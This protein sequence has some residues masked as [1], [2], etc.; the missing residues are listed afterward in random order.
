[1]PGARVGFIVNPLAGIGGRLGFKGSDGAYGLRALMEGAKPVSPLRARRFAAELD[2]IASS[3]G[4]ELSIVAPPGIMGVDSLGG[5]RSVKVEVIS[6]VSPRLWPTTAHDTIRCARMM[7]DGGVDLIVFVGGDGTARNMCE[8][9]GTEVPAL[10][11]PSG[12]KVY[13]SVFAVNPEAAAR[14]VALFSRGGGVRL[15]ERQVVD[16]DEDEFRRGNLVIRFFCRLL[17]PIAGGVV[18]ATKTPVAGST[19]DDIAEY[20]AS[21]LVEDCT[22]YILGP[23]STVAAIAGKMGV[24][25]SFLGVDA[26]HNG[27]LVGVDLSE[28]GILELLDKYKRAVVIVSPIGGQGFI[29]GRGNQQISPEILRRVGRDNLLVVASPEKLKELRVLRVDTG[30]P[31][32]D[33]MLRGYI[34]VLV[35]YDRWRVMRV[36]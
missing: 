26:V 35:G 5:L 7:R 12:V 6:C 18:E 27:R 36:E 23:G 4:L 25:K 3:E 24:P 9:I 34:R 33:E 30:D 8:A 31:E 13:S 1:M 28:K 10:G 29:F 2:R 15:E 32:V 19:V 22:L 11:V 21:H 20:V 14:V 16:V 17:T